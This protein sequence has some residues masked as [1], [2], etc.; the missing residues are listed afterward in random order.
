VIKRFLFT[1][2]ILLVITLGMNAQSVRIMPLGNSITFDQNSLDKTNPRNDADRISYRYRL[3]QQLYDEGYIFDYV[4]S[5]NA[6][7]N[8]FQNT[9]LDDNAGFPAIETWQLA[10]LIN[11]GYNE[12]TGYYECPGPYLSYYSADIILIHIGTNDLIES[13]SEVEDLL[14][15]IRYFDPDVHILVARIVN[16]RNYHSATTTFNNNV[17]L[18]VN[19]RGDPRIRMVNME[20]GAGINYSTDMID[21]LHPN[22]NGYNKMGE[23][24]FSAIKSLNQAPVVDQILEQFTDREIAFNPISLDDYV[25][26]TE[27][28]DHSLIWTYTGEQGTRLN[29]YINGNRQL[30]VS[31]VGDWYGSE[32]L[33]L[34]VTDT[35]NGAF[36]ENVTMDVVFTVENSNDPP[37]ILSSPESEIS[38]DETYYYTVQAYD[39]D[40]DPITYSAVQKPSWLDFNAITH[41]LSGIPHND[42]VGVHNIILRVADDENF[43]EQSYELEVIDINDEPEF[44]SDPI[45]EVIAQ[46]SYIYL[47]T[48]EDVDSDDNLSFTAI[49][50]PD[51]L[52]LSSGSK[53]ALLFGTTD[54]SHIGSH[55]VIIQLSDGEAEVIQGFNLKVLNPVSVEDLT[56]DG[57]LEVYPNPSDGVFFFKSDKPGEIKLNIYNSVGVLQKTITSVVE[58]QIRIDISNLERNIYIYEAIINGQVKTGKL[59]KN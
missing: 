31:P 16:R 18:M 34:K 39:S 42:H 6:G 56:S 44:T 46:E 53:D 12:V 14:D 36:P 55:A 19:M 35:G 40:G 45:S 17:E 10:N 33:S 54:M 58:E 25:S 43:T 4:G 28:Q 30:M 22:Q 5:E 21:D 32:T 37:V 49:T 3:Y 48:A 41:Q 57:M 23:K 9:E 38:Q 13:A 2:F 8:Y 15:N 27:D 52:T 51:W 20:T 47:I 24:W 50:I 26:D 1:S 11:S 59:I 29:V 7:L